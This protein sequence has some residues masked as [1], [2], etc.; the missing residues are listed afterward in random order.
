[1]NDIEH[2]V[3]FF[4]AHQE[5]VAALVRARAAEQVTE[6][7]AQKRILHLVRIWSAKA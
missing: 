6:L 2:A 7:E 1:M 4:G 3:R 5:E